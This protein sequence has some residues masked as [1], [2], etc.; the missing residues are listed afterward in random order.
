VYPRVTRSC[1]GLLQVAL[2]LRYVDS[3]IT[4]TPPANRLLDPGAGLVD[5]ARDLVTGRGK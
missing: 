1:A 3:S 2:P 5:R 4:V